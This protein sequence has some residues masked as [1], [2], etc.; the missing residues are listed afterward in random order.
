M[1]KPNSANSATKGARNM[2]RELRCVACGWA[3]TE[4]PNLKEPY[5][6]PVSGGPVLMIR[7]CGVC[8]EK[9]KLSE[10]LANRRSL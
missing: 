7:F 2:N 5:G 9:L 6:P 1:N 8:W 3:L 10:T 4:K